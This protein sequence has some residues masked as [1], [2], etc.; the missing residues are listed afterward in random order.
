MLCNRHV[1]G[2]HICAQVHRCISLNESQGDSGY[3]HLPTQGYSQGYVQGQFRYDVGRSVRRR[4]EHW[5]RIWVGSGLGQAKAYAANMRSGI[6]R[7]MHGARLR[8]RFRVRPR[9]SRWEDVCRTL[10]L[11]ARGKN[12]M[13]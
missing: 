4:V 2:L 12:A 11:T 7:V 6:S 8:V 9:N 10:Q 5:A 3:V 1:F 13:L